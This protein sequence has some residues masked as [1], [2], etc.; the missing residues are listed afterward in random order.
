MAEFLP[1]IQGK[2]ALADFAA[3]TFAFIISLFGDFCNFLGFQTRPNAFKFISCHLICC[4]KHFIPLFN[5]YN[6]IGFYV[7]LSKLDSVLEKNFRI[8]LIIL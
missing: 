1:F 8:G 3:R 4:K 2:S 5:Y 6:A 7:L